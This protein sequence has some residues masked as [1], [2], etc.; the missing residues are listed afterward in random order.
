[1]VNRKIISRIGQFF[2]YLFLLLLVSAGCERFH[3]AD[4]VYLYTDSV[5]HPSQGVYIF[6]GAIINI[7]RDEISQHGFCWSVNQDPGISTDSSTSLGSRREIGQFSSTVADLIP[8]STYYVRAYVTNRSGTVYGDE[9]EFVSDPPVTGPDIPVV[10]TAGI[11]LVTDSSARCGGEVTDDG[12]SA[13]LSRGICWSIS[14]D[15][16][17]GD[18]HTTEGSGSGNFTSDITGLTCATRYYV[19]AYATNSAG[20]GYGDTIGFETRACPASIPVV[21]TDEVSNIT[22]S[23]ASCG[24]NVTSD[25]GDPV[26]VRGL[27][28]GREEYPDLSDEITVNG[29]GIGPFESQITGLDCDSVYYVRA[30]A[31]NSVGTAFGSQ[32]MFTTLACPVGLPTVETSGITNV[33]TTS[34][35]VGGN[36][37]DDGG[38]PVTKKGVCW[39][40]SN[41]PD[42]TDQHTYDGA[43]L[44]SYTSSL[45]GLLPGTTYYVR[46]YATNSEGTVYGEEKS[47]ITLSLKGTVTDYDGNSYET[48]LIGNQTWM[49]ANLKVTHYSD[50]SSLVDGAS[51]G[52]ITGDRTTKYHFA[53]NNESSRVETHGRLYSWAAVVNGISGSDGLP[54]GI[55][56]VCPTGWHLPSDVEWQELE[57][58]LGMSVSQASQWNWRGS[59]QGT[60]LKEDGTSGFEAKLGG[61]RHQNGNSLDFG[62]YGYFWSTTDDGVN[63][64]FRQ[65]GST[66]SQIRRSGMDKSHACSVRCVKD[67]E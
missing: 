47:F 31:T 33:T 21:E 61:Y 53:H 13:I 32:K 34:A 11:T 15:P 22:I 58:Q 23:S 26:T 62:N 55:Q 38:S 46:A 1:M 20:T 44:G 17:L 36:V 54:S 12:G 41:D 4:Q 43:G 9:V 67:T 57:K 48:V 42:T 27:C 28:W 37:S 66:S 51:A 10:I 24:G 2:W 40:N 16:T 60:Q 30:Y 7:G 39:S 5:S 64:Y 56:G 50:G 59:D 65:V 25:G 63:A 6:K 18:D 45:T 52:D 3:P 29:S 8:S 35:D 49:A 19:R 14:E